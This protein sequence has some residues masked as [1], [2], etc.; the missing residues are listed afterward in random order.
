LELG[1]LHHCKKRK[2]KSQ[3]KN[4]APGRRSFMTMLLHKS[5]KNA[6]CD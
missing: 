5:G 2:E 4:G 6:K 3:K 1:K